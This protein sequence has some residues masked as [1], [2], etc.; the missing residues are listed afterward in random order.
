M[1]LRDTNGMHSYSKGLR[2]MIIMVSVGI[3]FAGLQEIIYL[4][5]NKKA[6]KKQD[7]EGC[8]QLWLYVP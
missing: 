1:Q 5:Y 8:E 2:T 7:E 4:R 6:L 3:L